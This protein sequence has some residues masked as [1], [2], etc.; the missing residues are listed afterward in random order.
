MIRIVEKGKTKSIA[1]IETIINNVISVKDF[2][3]VMFYLVNHDMPEE[4]VFDDE[5]AKN[6]EYSKIVGVLKSFC[7]NLKIA[8]PKIKVEKNEKISRQN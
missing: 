8:V 3:D 5:P 1:G 7:K 2:D 4:I 6:P